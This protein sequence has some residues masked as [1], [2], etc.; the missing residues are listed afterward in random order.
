MTEEKTI[1]SE[2]VLFDELEV[3]EMEEVVAPAIVVTN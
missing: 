3:E 2:G 1:L